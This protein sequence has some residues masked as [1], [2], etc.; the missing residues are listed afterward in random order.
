MAK[1][2]RVKEAQDKAAKVG[3][4]KKKLYVSTCSLSK[5]KVSRAAKKA[6]TDSDSI[7]NEGVM[8]NLM[9][10]LKTG[11]AFSRDHKRKRTARPSGGLLDI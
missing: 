10:A 9:E 8:D 4:Q 5:D 11:S 1:K 3:F 2:G 7:E 6:L